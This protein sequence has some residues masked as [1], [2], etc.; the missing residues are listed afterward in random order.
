MGRLLYANESNK[1]EIKTQN[2][3]PLILFYELRSETTASQ[4]IS[5]ILTDV[6]ST[7]I[8]NKNLFEFKRMNDVVLNSELEKN[9]IAGCQMPYECLMLLSKTEEVDFFIFGSTGLI[10]ENYTAILNIVDV[11]QDKLL[12]R[13]SVI[14]E[15]NVSD[16]VNRSIGIINQFVEYYKKINVKT[17]DKI[18]TIHHIKSESQS[19]AGANIRM[20][21]DQKDGNTLTKYFLLG[22]GIVGLV[23]GGIFTYN[24]SIANDNYK[25]GTNPEYWD[26]KIS[27]YNILSLTSYI[28]GGALLVGSGVIFYFDYKNKAQFN[29]LTHCYDLNFQSFT[30]E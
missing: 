28:L 10:G 25:E 24:A 21:R 30:R 2:K 6:I 3:K 4:D 14:T 13:E 26:K 7:E 11:K 5:N 16:I 23:L 29:T 20:K 18:A 12:F 8:M 17:Q 22:G 15:K 1:V 19:E 9:G 27:F